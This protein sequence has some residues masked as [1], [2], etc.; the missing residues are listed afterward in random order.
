MHSYHADVHDEG[1]QDDCGACMEHAEK[2]ATLDAEM[3][4]NL[5]VMTIKMRQGNS[6]VYPRSET[7]AIA[8]ANVMNALETVGKFMEALQITG[9]IDYIFDYFERFWRINI[10]SY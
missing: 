1:L 5:V 9:R 8:R 7:E 3:L 10:P 4:S 6:D 2:L